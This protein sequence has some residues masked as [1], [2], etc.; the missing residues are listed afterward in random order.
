LAVAFTLLLP[1]L[2]SRPAAAQMSSA[3]CGTENLIA[4]R[5]P[6]GQQDAHGVPG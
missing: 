3:L 1:L 5:M 6:A 4:G 2:L